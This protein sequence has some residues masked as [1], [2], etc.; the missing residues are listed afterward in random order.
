MR[1]RYALGGKLG[2]GAHGA[3]YRGRDTL[4][5]RLVAVKFLGAY[6]PAASTPGWAALSHPNIVAVYETAREG[7]EAYL[8]MERVT[9]RDLRRHLRPGR[10][11]ALETILSVIVRIADALDHAHRHGL[12][13]GDVNP[14]NILFD[15]ARDSVKLADFPLHADGDSAAPRG[16]G[17]FAYMSPEQVCGGAPEAAS[18]QFALG[19]TLYRLACGH[20]AFTA[21]TRPRLAS[22]IAAEPHA[23]IRTRDS[24]L[25]AGLAETL[26]RMLEKRPAARYARMGDA[27]DALRQIA[28]TMPGSMDGCLR[29]CAA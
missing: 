18:D 1:D 14:A 23:D 3:V 22:M 17:T 28:A 13:H 27:A 29:G 9:G 5:G 12:V 20:P 16:A 19:A 21:R 2:A 4:S 26:D 8:V 6:A 25:P 7:D 10:L 24:G 11:L 15:P